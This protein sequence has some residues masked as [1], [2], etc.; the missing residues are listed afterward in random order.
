M[1]GDVIAGVLRIVRAFEDMRWNGLF[2]CFP[3]I[4][5]TSGN[6]IAFNSS[7]SFSRASRLGII[8][9]CP[10]ISSNS[11]PNLEVIRATVGTFLLKNGVIN[12]P[13]ATSLVEGLGL[14]VIAVIDAPGRFSL[15]IQINHRRLWP[16]LLAGN[17]SLGNKPAITSA[18]VC[19]SLATISH[20]QAESPAFLAKPIRSPCRNRDLGD[21]GA[22]RHVTKGIRAL[23]KDRRGLQGLAHRA[24]LGRVLVKA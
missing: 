14:S 21:G 20:R 16:D 6:P 2:G 9:G 13:T 23:C 5:A 15:R 4:M 19:K 10:S 18:R 11:P 7:A 24:G 1:P 3:T 17:T 12:R 22:I 8:A